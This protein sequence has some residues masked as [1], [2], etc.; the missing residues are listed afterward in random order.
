[1]CQNPG[2]ADIGDNQLRKHRS[3]WSCRRHFHRFLAVVAVSSAAFG[4]TFFTTDPSDL[5]WNSA[6]SGWGLQIVQ[7]GDAS[8]ATLYV[9]DVAGQPAFYTATLALTTSTTWSGD[10]YR[11]IG[12]WFG[13]GA[14]SP[15]QV[16]PRKVGTLT[17]TRANSDDATL[18]YT[19]DGVAVSKNVT[20]LTLHY[21]NYGGTYAA[22]VSTETTKC[23]DSADSR[24]Q[25]ALRTLRIDHVGNAMTI[26]GNL[27]DRSTCTYTGTYTQA[28]R[29]GAMGS[30]SYTCTDGD[31]GAMTFFELT[32]RPGMISGRFQG[33]SIHDACDYVGRLTGLS[34]SDRD[35]PGRR[36][37]QP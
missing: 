22:T 3:V 6:E 20:R 15:F 25:T 34:R 24:T 30:G 19:V 26:R 28:G 11:T 2:P 17:F 37:S 36:V 31:E 35:E 21:D 5:W 23:S 12:P 9:Y 1:M 18:Q 16:V 10:L 33:H 7:G 8:F 29:I 14:F 27:I 32:R 4:Q 13:A